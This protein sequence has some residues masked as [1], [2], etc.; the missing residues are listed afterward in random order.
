MKLTAEV[1]E[2]K[3]NHS[4][5][6]AIQRGRGEEKSFKPQRTPARCCSARKRGARGPSTVSAGR[7][8]FKLR[9]IMPRALTSGVWSA[10]NDS[11]RTRNCSRAPALHS[12]AAVSVSAERLTSSSIRRSSRAGRLPQ[13][14]SRAQK[15][16][17]PSA[18]TNWLWRARLR[19]STSTHHTQ[20][21]TD[22]S[23]AGESSRPRKPSSSA[24]PLDTYTA[25]AMP[26]SNI[27][28][29]SARAS[30]GCM[31]A[32]PLRP[33]SASSRNASTV[34]R[35]GPCTTSAA[36]PL[37]PPPLLHMNDS[38]HWVK[39]RAV[40][41]ARDPRG[42]SRKVSKAVPTTQ[43]MSSDG[44]IRAARTRPRATPR[45]S[46]RASRSGSLQAWSTTARA[47]SPSMPLS[48]DSC[49]VCTMWRIAAFQVSEVGRGGSS[50]QPPWIGRAQGTLLTTTGQSARFF[51]SHSRAQTEWQ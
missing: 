19:Q 4:T 45:S 46:S 48:M 14:W 38:S 28:S 37:L 34:N 32:A 31:A 30:V 47:A 41:A 43:L 29:V 49:S 21:K 1:P 17:T 25:S 27:I 33:L 16:V 10:G 11:A 50:G 9:M 20:K 39:A 40:R 24:M 2:V 44:A 26:A 13:R 15:T 23:A 35:C 42:C 7:V 3:R 6:P 36:L 51:S 5:Q 12:R 22:C 8:S 18:S